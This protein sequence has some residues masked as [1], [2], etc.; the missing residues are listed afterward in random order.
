[1]EDCLHSPFKE[2]D[3]FFIPLLMGGPIMNTGSFADI[4]THALK[5]CHEGED[6]K[7]A[8]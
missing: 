3:G 4:Y 5:S 7:E 8:I 1:M 6:N 2:I